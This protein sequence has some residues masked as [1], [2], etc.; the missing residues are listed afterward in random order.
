MIKAP[1]ILKTTWML[2]VER[3]V[4]ADSSNG[5]YIYLSQPRF[6]TLSDDK[7]RSYISH[8]GSD[9]PQIYSI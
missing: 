3:I 1:T 6:C 4:M 5:V 2:T 8:S 9:K 7:I